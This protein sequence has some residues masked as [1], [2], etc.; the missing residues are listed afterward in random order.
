[1]TQY[2]RTRLALANLAVGLD[3][4]KHLGQH[5]AA[6]NVTLFPHRVLGC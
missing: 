1:M 3:F 5:R 4:F 2:A 6:R